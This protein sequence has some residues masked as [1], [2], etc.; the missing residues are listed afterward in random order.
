MIPVE[1]L[2]AHIERQPWFSEREAGGASIAEVE[3]LRD[4]WPAMVQVLVSAVG[5]LYQVVAGIRPEGEAPEYLHGHPEALIGPVSTPEGAGVAYDAMADP[6]LCRYLLGLVAP[7]EAASLARVVGSGRAGTSVVYDDRL[8]LKLFRALEPGPN[9]EVEMTAALAHVGFPHVARPVAAWRQG[10][11][12]L[13]VVHEFLGGGVKGWD[14]A[15]TS[16]RDLLAEPRLLT[17]GEAG[18]DFAG[19]A[20]RLGAMTAELHGALAAALGR[21][22]ADAAGWAAAIEREV[23]GIVGHLSPGA[24]KAARGVLRRLRALEDAGPAIRVH[25]NYQLSRVLRT[26]SGWYAVD[27]EGDP[28]LPLAQRRA[29]SS[30]LGDVAAMLRSFRHVASVAERESTG[31]VEALAAAWAARNREAFLDGYL[32]WAEKAGL[33]PRRADSWHAVISAFELGSAAREVSGALALLSGW[34]DVWV[35]DLELLLSS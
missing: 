14:L 13:A 27:F 24:A 15:L 35:R 25:G 16:L 17:P 18:G 34:V 12:D 32:P 33:L 3:V 5:R 23:G 9:P 11:L 31:E 6:E 29:F 30:P 10:E 26:D 4:G 22:P 2:A 28:A 8:I 21:R 19:E 7:S 20:E 1:L